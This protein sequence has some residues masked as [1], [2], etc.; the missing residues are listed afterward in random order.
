MKSAEYTLYCFA[1]S[2]NCYKA[3]L[4][5][6]LAGADWAPRFVDY[7]GGE[8][9]TPAYR[10]I[11]VMGEAPVLEH[12]GARLAQSGVILD[13]L[14]ETLGQVRPDRRRRAARDP[15]LAPLGQP[16]AHELHGDLPLHARVHQGSGSGGARRLPQARRSRVGRARRAPRRP[17]LRRRRS[18]DDRRPFAVR[19]PVL[20]RGDRRRLGRVSEHPRLARAHPSRAA[21]GASVQA[22]AR[23]SAAAPPDAAMSVD[24]NPAR[25]ARRDVREEP[26]RDGGARRR[27]AREGRRD[28]AGRRRGP[29]AQARRARQAPAARAHAR[30]ARSRLA[31]PRVLA[32]RGVRHVRRQHRGGR[33]HHRHRPHRRAR[34]RDRLQRRDGQG[35]H[36]LS[37]DGEEAPARAG[38]RARKPSAVHLPGRFRRRQPAEPD[39]RISRPRSLRPHLLQPGD[40]VGGGHPAD[41]RRDGLVHRGRRVRAGDVRRVDH[42]QGAGHDLPGRTAA[43]EGR[44]G[45]D[46]HA[47]RSWAAPTSTRACR[48]SPTTSR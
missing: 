45:R 8:T 2:G 3:A 1:Q 39:R 6:E 31:V 38:H 27:P 37:D 24:R 41:R 18:L 43:G 48:A 29:R 35:R 14:A 16:Q 40:D 36:V 4:A 13:Y 20:A 10:E 32:A 9:R 11:N 33:H 25:S 42:R 22:D 17:P 5:L 30:A 26:R 15:A 19:L 28:R 44:D 7:F 46:R 23:P 34:M 12:R 47:P 21:L